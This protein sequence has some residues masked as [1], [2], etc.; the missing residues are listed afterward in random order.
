MCYTMARGMSTPSMTSVN[1]MYP[2]DMNNCC[3]GRPR[4]KGEKYKKL[5]KSYA[6]VA[7]A[8]ATCDSAGI[9]PL[10]ENKNWRESVKY[11]HSKSDRARF[12]RREGSV[13]IV[14]MMALGK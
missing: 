4:G 2:S 8:G 3:R 13:V 12:G 5:K 1:C 10:K 11:L 6:S 9:G 14:D 7:A